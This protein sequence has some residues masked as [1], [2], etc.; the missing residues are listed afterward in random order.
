MARRSIVLTAAMAPV[1]VA[2]W[3]SSA[4]TTR[5]LLSVEALAIPADR[6]LTAFKIDTWGVEFLAVCRV[7]PSWEIK[8]EKYED[9]EGLLSGRADNHGERLTKLRDLFLVDVYDYQPLP[10]GNPKSDYHPASFAG[11]IEMAAHPAE[12]GKRTTLRAANFRLIKAARCPD[13]PSPQ[14]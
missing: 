14:R 6:S 3:P 13:P 5:A 8:A 2:A 11:W 4:A 10:R 1:L 12:R 7:P 9:P